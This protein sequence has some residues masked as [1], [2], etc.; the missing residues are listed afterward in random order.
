MSG[1]FRDPPDELELPET[2][3]FTPSRHNPWRSPKATG[4][5][6]TYHQLRVME[7]LGMDP[8]TVEVVTCRSKATQR[9]FWIPLNTEAPVYVFDCPIIGERPNG[10]RIVIAPAG[11]RKIIHESGRLDRG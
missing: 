7:G 11:D 2:M 6:F 9:E 3:H 8:A 4:A 1:F 10:R 5:R